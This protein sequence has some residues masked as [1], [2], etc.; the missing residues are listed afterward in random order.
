MRG[1]V[2]QAKEDKLSSLPSPLRRDSAENKASDEEITRL[3]QSGRVEFFDV[4][5]ERYEKKIKRYSRKFLSDR[6]DINDV[7]QDVFIKAYKNIQSFDVKRKFS[8]WLYRIAHNE[9]INALKKKKRKPLSL[10]DLDVFFPQRL[11][12]DTDLHG[13]IERQ[14]MQKTIDKSL[15]KLELKYREPIILYYFEGLSYK[16]IADVMRLPIS[17]VAVRIKRAKEAM[18]SIYK[19]LGHN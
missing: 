5:M 2:S 15:D 4:L 1:K 9:L 12:D 16:E 10:L 19:K 6:E 8:P 7:L 11:S 14:E 18:K 13:Q 3:V 17:T